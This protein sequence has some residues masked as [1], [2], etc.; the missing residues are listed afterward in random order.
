MIKL[1]TTAA[2]AAVTAGGVPSS[3]PI[4]APSPAAS[5]VAA[6]APPP[7]IRVPGFAP[8]LADQPIAGPADAWR[9][10]PDATV[11]HSI[12]TAA[13][14]ERQAA[15]W[16]YARSLIATGRGPDAI[17]VL[18]VMAADDPDLTLVAAWQRAHGVAQIQARHFAEGI[19][20]LRQPA[21]FGDAES[22]LW[23]MRAL[24]AVHDPQASLAQLACAAPALAVRHGS[25]RT[26]FILAGAQAASAT[27]RY[28]DVLSWL[29][30]LP[31][32]NSAANLLRGKANLALGNAQEGRLRLSRVG[33]SGSPEERAEASLSTIE[34]ALTTR[35]MD[36]ATAAKR[37]DTLLIGW[38]GDAIE[39]RALQLSMRLAQQNHDAMRELA[40]GAILSRYFDLGADAGPLVGTLQTRLAALLAPDSKLPLAQAV[41][42]FWDYRDFA[43]AGVEGLRF[44]E[45]LAGRLQSAG[46]YGRA[47]DL[48]DHRLTAATQQ[49]VEQGP[50]SIRIASLRILAGDPAAAVR[51][52]RATDQVPYPGDMV[53]Q[54]R[55]L[56]AVALDLLGKT[57]E[58][59]ATLDDVPD[60]VVISAEIYWRA[61]DWAH[62]ERV[63]DAVLPPVGRLNEVGQAIV[64]RQAITLAMLG[65]GDAL[66]RLHARY[67]GGF[68]GLPAAA[69]FELLAG[70]PAQVDPGALTKAMAALPATSPA[71]AIGDLMDA[72]RAAIA[73][74]AAAPTG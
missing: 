71:G 47:A 54:R 25:A 15:R 44:A 3:S 19:A 7:M 68:A 72:G 39:R 64:L 27:G 40:S 63:G 29:A 20:A 73:S 30:A 12:V 2:L 62:L 38:R 32:G 36:A 31:D 8:W 51:V 70:N 35:T 61:H 28:R 26:P 57:N 16:A 67:A 18:D 1:L 74:R 5:P 45:A 49:D 17:G 9:T 22:C 65:H 34:D 48:L 43:P 11:W 59:L 14:S 24:S 37:V 56:E 50:L 13:P 46:L 58:A 42:L 23:R 21:L 60:G 52:L 66:T 69:T 53:A 55:R 4:P 33:L 10:I 41:G 6:A